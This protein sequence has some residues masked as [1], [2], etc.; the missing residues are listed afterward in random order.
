MFGQSH[1]VLDLAVVE[2]AD[3][4][5]VTLQIR[6]SGLL[7]RFQSC[8]HVAEKA[9]AGNVGK[10]VGAKGIQTDVQAAYARFLQRCGQLRQAAAV[11]GHAQLLKAGDGGK[12]S[13]NLQNPVSYQRFSACKA[14]FFHA[15]VYRGPSDLHALFHGKNVAMGAFFHARFRHT[16]TAAVIAQV[17]HRKPQISNCPATA[18]RHRH[19][20]DTQLR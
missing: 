1:K 8:Q 19:L 5:H 10:T 12:A 17:C 15:A 13:A 16:V 2:S 9:P 18:I 6:K 11:G 3:Q 7:R 14:N 20:R 4:D